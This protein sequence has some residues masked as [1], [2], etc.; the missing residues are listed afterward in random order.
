[1]TLCKV[2]SDCD[3]LKGVCALFLLRMHREVD[4]LTERRGGKWSRMRSGLGQLSHA[5]VSLLLLTFRGI[6]G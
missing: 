5:G 6:W 3:P 1:M 4:D 2:F